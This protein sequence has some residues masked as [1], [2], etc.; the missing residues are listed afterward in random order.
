MKEKIQHEVP[1]DKEWV[2]DETRVFLFMQN[3]APG[4]L[5]PLE[6]HFTQ[7]AADETLAPGMS[8]GGRSTIKKTTVEDGAGLTV[9]LQPKLYFTGFCMS[10]G[11]VRICKINQNVCEYLVALWTIA[12][13]DNFWN[14]TASDIST[15]TK[16]ASGGVSTWMSK[17]YGFDKLVTESLT[18]GP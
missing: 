12:S 10:V 14:R 7:V 5:A 13:S 15:I 16:D 3:P 18:Q 8:T 9:T 17:C 1:G 11:F 6:C 2:R 4:C